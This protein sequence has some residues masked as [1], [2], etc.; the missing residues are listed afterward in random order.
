MEDVLYSLRSVNTSTPYYTLRS[1]LVAM[2][3]YTKLSLQN[4]EKAELYLQKALKT[5]DLSYIPRFLR[6]H[7]G[8][9]AAFYLKVIL[10]KIVTVTITDSTKL[11]GKK[12]KP[13]RV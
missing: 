7:E 2:N 8:K 13:P 3:E 9:Q 5:L 12:K 1:F 4:D 6:Y 11:K 10:D